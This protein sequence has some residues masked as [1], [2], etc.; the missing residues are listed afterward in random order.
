MSSRRRVPRAPAEAPARPRW[1]HVA[2]TRGKARRST[3]EVRGRRGRRSPCRKGGDR[4]AIATGSAN[5][6]GDAELEGGELFEPSHVVPCGKVE[7]LQT[8]PNRCGEAPGGV[9]HRTV[10]RDREIGPRY[11]ADAHPWHDR[12]ARRELEGILEHG[13]TAMDADFTPYPALRG[14]R[15]LIAAH[16]HTG[17]ETQP[18]THRHRGSDAHLAHVAVERRALVGP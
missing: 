15:G 13:A 7:A 1:L 11:S 10:R 2:S 17:V 12:Q 5:L 4:G 14:K 8:V 16:H 6:P 18:I 9:A 3:K